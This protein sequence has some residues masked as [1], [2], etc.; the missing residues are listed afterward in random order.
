MTDK[1]EHQKQSAE[2]IE[3][4][5]EAVR[6][7]EQMVDENGQL[8]EDAFAYSDEVTDNLIDSPEDADI[9]ED[10]DVIV[11]V[12]AEESEP[13][14]SNNVSNNTPVK[15]GG[16]A[17]VVKVA[18][19][20]LVGLL[21]A[22][23]VSLAALSMGSGETSA[24]TNAEAQQASDDAPAFAVL[25]EPED[26]AG[27]GALVEP[28]EPS[29]TAPSAAF[30][31]QELVLPGESE[32]T[33]TVGV[34]DIARDTLT[35][36]AD[37]VVEVFEGRT[38]PAQVDYAKAEQVDVLASSLGQ[39]QDSV[40]EI[41]GKIGKVDEQVSFFADYQ[42]AITEQLAGLEEKIGSLTAETQQLA[43]DIKKANAAISRQGTIVPTVN[44]PDPALVAQY[45]GAAKPAAVQQP[46]KA[47]T[48]PVAEQK[49][50]TIPP[51]RPAIAARPVVAQ[52][53][54]D[55]SSCKAGGKVSQIWRVS[56]ANQNAAYLF[57]AKDNFSMVVRLGTEVPGFGLVQGIDVANR[58]VCT[59]SGLIRR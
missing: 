41:E 2:D 11:P 16:G 36:A 24:N 52:P 55:Y 4:T 40:T 7:L 53:M 58:S 34:A 3:I 1:N 8:R 50:V 33:D 54:P 51:S 39:V 35:E 49:V 37:E 45:R 30:H 25:E 22:G 42:K 31:T 32:T 23:G 43:G 44:G 20:S 15:K 21:T 28:Q 47:K 46:V 29:S 19:I 59:T 5:P 57:R 27:F 26:D 6:Q 10:E 9:E 17:K 18:M 38:L 48:E 14:H 56:G 12:A 13:V